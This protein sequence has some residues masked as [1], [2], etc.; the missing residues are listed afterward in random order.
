MTLNLRSNW[1]LTEIISKERQKEHDVQTSQK[2]MVVSRVDIHRGD[3]RLL[4]RHEFVGMELE[5]QTARE[6]DASIQ[7]RRRWSGAYRTDG[8]VRY[9]RERTSNK[10]SHSLTPSMELFSH[11]E[12]LGFF[13]DVYLR[14]AVS[15]EW[16][17]SDHAVDHK[18]TG[19]LRLDLDFLKA[20]S[21]R[22]DVEVAYQEGEQGEV[23][24]YELYVQ[25]SA[26]F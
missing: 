14:P 6:H 24:H 1:S 26:D 8:E 2:D 19:R 17:Q 23:L 7:W 10:N 5:G 11:V 22:L 12:R 18:W 9:K 3:D 20:L 13:D 21:Q 4:L 15:F 16:K 25:L